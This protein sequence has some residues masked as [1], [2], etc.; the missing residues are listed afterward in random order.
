MKNPVIPADI[1]EKVVRDEF[2]KC[3]KY[4]RSNKNKYENLETCDLT[5]NMSKRR[6]NALVN[7][8]EEFL[9]RIDKFPEGL[10]PGLCDVWIDLNGSFQTYSCLDQEYHIL[11]AASVWIL[12]QL[13]KQGDWGKVY[14][15]LP[16]DDRVLED[17]YDK[18]VW[19]PEFH[20]DLIISI[21]YVLR[22]RNR[23]ETDGADNI[24][25]LTSDYLAEKS[26]SGG[27]TQEAAGETDQN[28]KNYDELIELISQEAMDRAVDHFRTFFWQWTERYIG[29]VAPFVQAYDECER[30]I[31]EKEAQHQRMEA[32]LERIKK[33]ILVLRQKK[34]KAKP[35]PKTI[36][37]LLVNPQ[38]DP[39]EMLKAFEPGKAG[40][41]NTGIRYAPPN[42]DQA[43]LVKTIDEGFALSRRIDEL[44]QSINEDIDK[45][46][47]L[48]EY[49]DSYVGRMLMV[50]RILRKEPT[51]YGEI[52]LPVMEPM[53]IPDP[54]ELCFALL[55]L[56]EKDDDL[57]W[58]YGAGCGFMCE[59]TDTL[60]WGFE[61]YDE[62]EDETWDGLIPENWET[63]ALPKSI[64]IP[65]IYHRVY[66]NKGSSYDDR[67]SLAQIVYERTGCVLPTDLQIYNDQTGMLSRYGI[68]GKDAAAVLMLMSTL[69]TIRRSIEAWNLDPRFYSVIYSDDE[70]SE[71]E[72]ESATAR[73]KKTEKQNKQENKAD[74]ETLKEEIKR[75]RAALHQSDKENRE[76][77][78]T[79]ASLKTRAERERRELADLRDYVFNKSEIAEEEKAEDEF[80]WPYEVQKDTVVFGGHPAW[81]NGIKTHLS[82]EI[83]FIPKEL[84]FDIG[85]IKHADVIWLQP[86]ALSHALFYRIAE[87]ARIYGVPM[88][89]FVYS[90]W[91][92]CALQVVEADK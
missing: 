2:K 67:R 73:K 77:K 85:I 71:K 61:E 59:V 1:F 86:N 45:K 91:R 74:P 30:R 56:A 54:Y 69:A 55:Y 18:D 33:S 79:L 75:L 4:L 29:G 23:I 53:K 52:S 40:L 50:G 64:V 63:A 42:N 14:K 7:T 32:E 21:E 76:I 34:N 19:Y 66:H 58:L 68:R 43:E 35:Q 80:N 83:R 41:Q 38:T 49:L 25:T 15:L 89:Y 78:K 13:R 6:Q 37:P 3:R 20:D 39:M 47:E 17:L 48:E 82:G 22:N 46:S 36:N 24:R 72:S 90:S 70:M 8:Y 65:D 57:P 11:Y 26:I 62:M 87:A 10:H 28:R 5:D 88:R 84:N 51:E 16:S 60:P 9:K 44:G 27:T 12:Q 31:A 81:L 92:K